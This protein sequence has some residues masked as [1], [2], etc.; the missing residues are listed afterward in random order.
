M[1]IENTANDWLE[2]LIPI[3]KTTHGAVWENAGRHLR[4]TPAISLAQHDDGIAIRHGILLPH[5]NP[6]A[7]TNGIT[8][9]TT[10]FNAT[11]NQPNP[12]PA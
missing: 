11:T 3:A 1:I 6:Q 9:A 4:H 12:T 5:T 2:L 8:A 10:L 7:I